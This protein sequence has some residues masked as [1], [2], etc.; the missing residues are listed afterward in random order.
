M[1]G[2]FRL[3][4]R[5]GRGGMAEVYLA[6]Q[7]SLQRPV[8]VK[9]LRSELLADPTHL[10][11]FRAEALAAAGLSHPNIIQVYS[12]GE[13]GGV[14]YIVQEYVHGQNL[15]ELLTRKGPLD[16]AAALHVMKQ[17]ASALSAAAEA[18]IIHRD[19][20]PENI[21]LTRKG[22]VKVADFGLAKLTQ[23]DT[24]MNLTKVGVTM[25]TPLYMSP[26][27]VNGAK[28]DQRSDL[29]SFGVTCYH[30]LAGVPPFRGESALSIAVKHLQEAPQ[31]L[32]EL[33]PDLPPLLCKIVHKMMEKDVARRYSSAV[34]LL[35]DL[36][37]L[38]QEHAKK[39]TPPASLAGSAS[40]AS[41][42]VRLTETG[43]PA[44]PRPIAAMVRFADRPLKRHLVAF[45]WIGL[46]T[47]G[48]SAGVGWMMRARVPPPPR[49]SYAASD[50][51]LRADW[52]STR[53]EGASWVS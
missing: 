53:T 37:R 34:A 33:R 44:L 35:K 2:E 38:S 1:L 19:I 14:Q 25:G 28:L 45:L 46:L 36:R 15:R 11:R 40:T 17:V 24:P 29:Y 26:E 30:M 51:D 12:I 5:L 8:A 39:D 9:V 4:R 31:P 47:A 16:L 42:T 18:G 10:A 49:V 50:G 43:L 6:E 41:K 22:E 32:A 20:K 27:Q 48:L 7:T 13:A 3:L 52:K 21:M 23:S